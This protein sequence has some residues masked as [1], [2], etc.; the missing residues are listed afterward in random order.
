MTEPKLRIILRKAGLP[1][2][3]CSEGIYTRGVRV[4]TGADGRRQVF[5]YGDYN[6]QTGTGVLYDMGLLNL[7]RRALSRAG[8]VAVSRKDWLVVNPK[9][10]S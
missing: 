5:A 2:S 8:V 1:T 6:T 4:S 10:T 9:G 3:K 7:C